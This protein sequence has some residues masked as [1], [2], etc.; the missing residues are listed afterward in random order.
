MG[1][2]TVRDLLARLGRVRVR[3]PLGSPVL[4]Y[5]LYPNTL[6]FLRRDVHY[7]CLMTRHSDRPLRRHPPHRLCEGEP[8]RPRHRLDQPA[9]HPPVVA[10]A[11]RP[12]PLELVVRA[13]A[14]AVQLFRERRPDASH[15]LE[16]ICAAPARGRRAPSSPRRV[17]RPAA[18]GCCWCGP[19]GGL[20]P[21]AA[22]LQVRLEGCEG[23]LPRGR[24]RGGPRRAGRVGALLL[25]QPAPHPRQRLGVDQRVVGA[26]QR[27]AAGRGSLE[28]G[29]EREG[30]GCA[31][32]VARP[33]PQRGARQRQRVDKGRPRLAEQRRRAASRIA[34]AAPQDRDVKPVAVVRRPDERPRLADQ[35]LAEPALEGCP[36]LCERPRTSL[37][38]QLLGDAG[39]RG[40]ARIDLALRHHK[41]AEAGAALSP[42]VG[43][44][45][46]KLDDLRLVRIETGR[47]EVKGEAGDPLLLRQS[48]QDSA[49]AR[50]EALMP[51]RCGT[52]S[53]AA[54]PGRREEG[55]QSRHSRRR[56]R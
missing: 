27:A 40:G 35:R 43:H 12:R 14:L 25:D 16:R 18:G 48:R 13:D 23:G 5:Y 22:V 33:G 49:A 52:N 24:R 1:N 6:L 36:H 44:D 10:A 50:E 30:A 3:D 51:H 29:S 41:L 17:A 53:A 2:R 55:E 19:R 47:L 21:V 31:P 32:G 39:D 42:R 37:C 8:V 34:H 11:L 56:R 15:A 38:Q 26:L 28:E 7:S 46:R 20:E 9:E 54:R 4:I 45:A